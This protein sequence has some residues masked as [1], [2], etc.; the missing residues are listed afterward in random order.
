M[1]RVFEVTWTE[2][3]QHSYTMNTAELAAVLG[4]SPVDLK[5]MPDADVTS[6]DTEDAADNLNEYSEAGFDGVCRENIEITVIRKPAKP[7]TS[8]P[9]AGTAEQND[10]GDTAGSTPSPQ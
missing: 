1:P 9:A 7:R 10:V 2:I 8:R 4:I 5:A 3:S 6:A